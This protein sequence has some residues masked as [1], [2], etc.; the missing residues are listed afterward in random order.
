PAV[1]DPFYTRQKRKKSGRMLEADA[2]LDSALYDSLKSFGRGYTRVQDFFSHFTVR[3]FKRLLV[4]LTSD[5]LTFGAMGAVLMTALALSAMDATAS[6]EFNR[7]EDYAIVFLDRY[8][9]E[10]GRRGIRADDSVA[11]SEI[12]DYLIR[13]TLATEDRRFYEHYGI[14][15]W[16][17]LRAL[18]S[19][20]EGDSGLQGGSSIT[21]QLAKLLFLTN[22]RTLE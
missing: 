21:Q 4:E 16:G 22:E 14:D 9:N 18:L 12:P 6:G 1:Q 20:V 13:A 15:V 5:A 11:L 2:W 19:N 8:G 17:T 10:I 3:G 7:A